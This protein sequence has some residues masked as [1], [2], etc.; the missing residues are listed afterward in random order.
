M[1]RMKSHVRREILLLEVPSQASLAFSLQLSALN[2]F[3][4]IFNHGSRVHNSLL[5]TFD[6]LLARPEQPFFNKVVNR[7]N[8]AGVEGL[9]C[10]SP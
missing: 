6:P 5:I 2:A 7:S 3:D 8:I 9:L 10:Y 1:H 4:Q